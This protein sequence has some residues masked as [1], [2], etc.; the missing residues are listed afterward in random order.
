MQPNEEQKRFTTT[1]VQPF[2]IFIFMRKKSNIKLFF[3]TAVP[4][5]ISLSF[6]FFF[7]FF[8]LPADHVACLCTAYHFFVLHKKKPV[9]FIKI[10]G[11][12]A[13]VSAAAACSSGKISTMLLVGRTR[14][15]SIAIRDLVLSVP[16]AG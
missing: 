11:V 5:L 1:H 15:R 14:R 9:S 2:F 16:A 10:V 6:F 4:L 8:F 13:G 3:G 7:F 12:L